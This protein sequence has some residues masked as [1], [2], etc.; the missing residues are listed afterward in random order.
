MLV[1]D[2]NPPG[3]LVAAQILEGVISCEGVFDDATTTSFAKTTNPTGGTSSQSTGALPVVS[4]GETVNVGLEWNSG[5]FIADLGLSL[6]NDCVSINGSDDTSLDVA[7]SLGDS[8]STTASYTVPPT[9]QPGDKICDRGVISGVTLKGL[10]QTGLSEYSK[11]VCFEVG[12]SAATPETPWP[13]LLVVA[14]AGLLGGAVTLRRRRS[15]I[16]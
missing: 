10:L 7:L 11:I 12:P 9:A 2:A 13:V 5:D 6:N 16:A 3:D 8:G 4:P 1:A 14:G 15:P